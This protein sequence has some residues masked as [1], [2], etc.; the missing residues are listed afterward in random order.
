MIVGRFLVTVSEQYVV[1]CDDVSEAY[2]L[3]EQARDGVIV[4]GVRMSD[5]NVY[6]ERAVNG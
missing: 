1:V 3:V 5:E 2:D 6:V 4:A